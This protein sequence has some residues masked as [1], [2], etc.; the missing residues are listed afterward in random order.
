MLAYA[1]V[2]NDDYLSDEEI[3]G[4]LDG[5]IFQKRNIANFVDDDFFHWV[6]GDQSFRNLR[7]AFRLIA[8]E[9]SRFDFTAVDEDVLKGVYQ[10]LIDLDTRHALGEYYT[11][12]WL[13][14]RIVGEFTFAPGDAILDPACGSGSFLRA[15]IHRIRELHPGS[16][17]EDVNDMVYGIDIHPLSVQIAKT[18]LL[19]ALGKGVIAAKRPIH[20]NVILANTL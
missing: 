12:D 6:T 16:S 15:A 14:E 1:F 10:E 11:P 13:C 5:S 7:K 18:T 20:L 8:Q 3:K 17:V 4:M 2:S 19:L 9:I